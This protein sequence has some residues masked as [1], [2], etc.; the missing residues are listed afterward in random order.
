MKRSLIIACL[1]LSA[2]CHAQLVVLPGQGGTVSNPSATSVSITKTI[3]AGALIVLVDHVVANEGQTVGSDKDGTATWGGTLGCSSNYE[4]GHYSNWFFIQSAVGGSTVFTMSVSSASDISLTVQAYSNQAAVAVDKCVSSSSSSATGLT[5]SVT[6]TAD[7]DSFVG[8]IYTPGQAPNSN[9]PLATLSSVTSGYNVQQINGVNPYPIIDV[10]LD[11]T[12]PNTAGVHTFQFSVLAPITNQPMVANFIAFK[13]AGAAPQVAHRGFVSHGLSSNPPASAANVPWMIFD[14]YYAYGGSETEALDKLSADAMVTYGAV[15]AGWNWIYGGVTWVTGARTGYALTPTADFPGMAAFYSYLHADGLKVQ[16]Y[17]AAGSA[18][19]IGNPGT[20]GFEY[21]DAAQVAGYGAD[22]ITLDSC[23]DFALNS[24]T[25]AQ[26]Q[27]EYQTMQSAIL[28]AFHKPVPFE[29]S[30]SFTS[31][32][33]QYDQIDWA[34]TVG[35]NSVSMYTAN[36]NTWTHFLTQLDQNHGYESY[37]RPGYYRTIYDLSTGQP[38]A[39]T[40]DTEGL[41]NMVLLA[42]EASPMI[43]GIDFSGTIGYGAPTQA[44]LTTIENIE[45]IAALKDPLSLT[46]GRVSQVSCGDAN[47]ECYTRPLANGAYMWVGF[48]RSSTTQTV[49]CSWSSDSQ[50]GPYTHSM[51]MVANW[52]GPWKSATAYVIG[53]MVWDNSSGSWLRYVAIANNTNK[54]PNSNPSDWSVLPIGTW[55]DSLGTLSTGY[56]ASVPSQGVWAIKVAP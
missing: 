33:N 32:V 4:S 22:G 37:V 10:L 42:V 13:S 51:D 47:C 28:T 25:N 14:P 39:G 48:N 31:P 35:G 56:S 46:H 53:N 19:G 26:V 3:T 21:P 50:S 9:Y 44:T 34:S 52:L 27:A 2:L 11:N 41:S 45:L 5:L 54:A 17:L 38:A 29:V 49:A 23:Y 36:T 16:S 43:T 30:L 20:F 55:H 40:T 12:G 15:A 18:C 8:T 1:L 24:W 6:T 7:N